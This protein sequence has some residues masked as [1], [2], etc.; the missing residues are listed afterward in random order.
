[1][2]TSEEF[3]QR[4]LA[5]EESFDYENGLMNAMGGV[6][7]YDY[8]HGEEITARDLALK[9]MAHFAAKLE[10]HSMAAYLFM[11]SM[12]CDKSC[13][14]KGGICAMLAGNSSLTTFAHLHPATPEADKALL[15][16]LIKA[17]NEKDIEAF[18]ASCAARDQI[19]SLD[20]LVTTLLLRLKCKLHDQI[21]PIQGE[22]MPCTSGH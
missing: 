2:D 12:V 11:I 21:S 6:I 15:T 14:L 7:M 19:E 17:V 13:G 16:N 4:A 1:M 8:D 22:S 5:C 18:S 9:Q 20:R 10:Q 3:L